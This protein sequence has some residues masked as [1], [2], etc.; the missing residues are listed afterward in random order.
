MELVHSVD[1]DQSLIWEFT[2]CPET[3]QCDIF[4]DYYGRKVIDEEYVLI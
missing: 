1:C 3:Y 2:V 4:M